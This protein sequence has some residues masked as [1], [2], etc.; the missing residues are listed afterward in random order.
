MLLPVKGKKENP[1]AV[2]PMLFPVF[3]HMVYASSD[4][5]A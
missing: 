3:L 4:S 5:H 1:T 2:L